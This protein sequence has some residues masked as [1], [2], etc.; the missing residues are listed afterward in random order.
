MIETSEKEIITLILEPCDVRMGKE[1]NVP[2]PSRFTDGE[3]KAQGVSNLSN[4][5]KAN[6]CKK[7]TRA[8][9][10]CLQI[11][12]LFRFSDTQMSYLHAFPIC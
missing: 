3:T 5:H 4:S 7:R 8:W 10:L 12:V 6:K 11:V 9:V 1:F 2:P